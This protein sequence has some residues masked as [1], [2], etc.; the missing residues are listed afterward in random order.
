MAGKRMKL[1]MQMPVFSTSPVDRKVLI[2]WE[3]AV[4]IVDLRLKLIE[5]I[6][7]ATGKTIWIDFDD[8]RQVSTLVAY[9]NEIQNGLPLLLR[10][11]RGKFSFHGFMLEHILAT[12]VEH[13]AMPS[14]EDGLKLLMLINTWRAMINK[15][16]GPAIGFNFNI[17][18][19]GIVATCLR[20]GVQVD[21]EGE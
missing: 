20:L 17:T 5:A 9:V 21:F 19:A 13:T 4:D 10:V 3:P 8:E 18:I 14:I 6:H 7:E 16:A 2:N 11:R 12:T 15:Q 1:S